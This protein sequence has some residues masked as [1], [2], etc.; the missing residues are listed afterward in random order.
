MLKIKN[1][2]ILLKGKLA[3]M[4]YC[5]FVLFFWGIVGVQIIIDIQKLVASCNPVYL[6]LVCRIITYIWFNN[7]LHEKKEK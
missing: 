5:N 6:R 7:L 1:R 4:G 2:G 3:A